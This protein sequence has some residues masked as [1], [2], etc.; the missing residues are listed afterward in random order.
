[1]NAVIVPVVVAVIGYTLDLPDRP[2]AKRYSTVVGNP[3]LEDRSKGRI[4]ALPRRVQASVPTCFSP[5]ARYIRVDV[6]TRVE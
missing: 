2:A 3:A 6:L 4:F 1:M 5:T